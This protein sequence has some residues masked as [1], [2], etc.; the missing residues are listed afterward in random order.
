MVL[1][2]NLVR[3]RLITDR[4][5]KVF[6]IF[7]DRL[8]VDLQKSSRRVGDIADRAFKVSFVLMD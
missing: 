6:F 7:M 8:D 1:D 2:V 3:K 4:T 5:F